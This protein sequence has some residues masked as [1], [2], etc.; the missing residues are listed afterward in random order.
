MTSLQPVEFFAVEDQPPVVDIKMADGVFIK[1][2]LIKKAG[3]FV[4]QHSHTYDHTSMLAVGAARV[5]EDGK[6]VGD[7]IAPAGL[8]IKAHTKHT[9]QALVD[10]TIV[11]CIHNVSRTGIVDVDEEHQLV[12]G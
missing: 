11:Y 1:Q 12:K 7:F 4:P 10:G 9:F 6:L 3:T 8:L 2:M 5:W